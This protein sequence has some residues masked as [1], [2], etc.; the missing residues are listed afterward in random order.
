MTDSTDYCDR[1][2]QEVN[3]D[4]E[5][6]CEESMCPFAIYNISSDQPLDFSREVK[7]EYTKE[8]IP[9]YEDDV[10]C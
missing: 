10:G 5:L 3:T 4:S 6:D 7:T 1:C 2:G 9:E 8:Y